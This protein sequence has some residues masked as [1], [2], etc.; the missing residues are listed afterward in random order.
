MNELVITYQKK[1]WNGTSEF[2]K[3]YIPNLEYEIR[4]SMV[5]LVNHSINS[6]TVITVHSRYKNGMPSISRY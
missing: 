2:H 3:E 4:S 5:L 6:F 1:V